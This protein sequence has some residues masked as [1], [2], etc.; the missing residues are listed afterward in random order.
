MRVFRVSC[1]TGEGVDELKHALFEL[2]PAE[3]ER[4]ADVE[5]LP[6]F[7]EYRPRPQGPRYRV[8]KTDRGFRVVGDVPAGDELEAA[9]RAAGV[10][11]GAEVEIGDEVLVWE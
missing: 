3:P 8:L 11:R 10:R 9:L 2:C 7:L 5:E 6:E 1:A 4:D